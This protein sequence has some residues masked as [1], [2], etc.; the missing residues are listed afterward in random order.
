VQS[1]PVPTDK[2]VQN[3]KIE[4]IDFLSSNQLISKELLAA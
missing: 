2:H 4:Q 1:K 3:S